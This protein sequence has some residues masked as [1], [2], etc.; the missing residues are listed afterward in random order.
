MN[1]EQAENETQILGT[2]QSRD[3][4]GPQADQFDCG[5]GVP[6]LVLTA[7]RPLSD[8]AGSGLNKGK[9][10]SAKLFALGSTI[11]GQLLLALAVLAGGS[12]LVGLVAAV[13]L[14]ACGL[15]LVAVD[16]I[17]ATNQG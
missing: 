12:A 17:G 2:E 16:V 11:L 9:G 13:I 6:G 3:V 10:I 1:S 5:D 14:L 8:G 4:A 15:A 7:Q